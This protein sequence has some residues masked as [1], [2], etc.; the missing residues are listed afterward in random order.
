M[1]LRILFAIMSAQV[2]TVPKTMRHIVESY[3][4]KLSPTNQNYDR[5]FMTFV[6]TKL[7]N[8]YEIIH[9]LYPHVETRLMKLS[10]L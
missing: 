10:E 2:Y 6:M 5:K 8:G 3:T 4:I 1:H 7:I 9:T